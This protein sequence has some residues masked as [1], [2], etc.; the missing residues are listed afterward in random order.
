MVGVRLG[1]TG[2]NRADAHFGHQL[3]R[4]ARFGLHVLQIVDQLCQILDR[5]DIVMRR[6]AKSGPRPGVE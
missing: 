4:D 1:N 6:W 5:V 3:D 2:G